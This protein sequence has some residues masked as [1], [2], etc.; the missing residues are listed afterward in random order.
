ML[1]HDAYLRKH[2]MRKGKYMKRT[3]S[4]TNFRNT[5]RDFTPEVMSKI[6]EISR[7]AESKRM[8]RSSQKRG[9]VSNHSGSVKQ[10][11]TIADLKIPSNEMQYKVS[12]G[13][14]SHKK[15]TMRNS[16]GV[17]SSYHNEFEII[18]EDPSPKKSDN[19][20]N[21]DKNHNEQ[22]SIVTS[23]TSLNSNKLE[24]SRLREK[25]YNQMKQKH[26][27]AKEK[28]E[29]AMRKMMEFV[30]TIENMGKTNFPTIQYTVNKHKRSFPKLKQFASL[31][32]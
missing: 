22:D 23:V 11:S 21:G 5:V 15:P 17:A 32:K 8:S 9:S 2:A 20:E 7:A 31:S 4:K 3:T 30:D 10:I 19:D 27:K 24:R 26:Q 13:N 18:K 28:H 14:N 1:D 16:T 12:F 29:K 25:K 6:E